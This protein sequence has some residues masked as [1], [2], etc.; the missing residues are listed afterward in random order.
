MGEMLREGSSRVQGGCNLKPGFYHKISFLILFCL[1]VF[2]PILRGQVD[3]TYHSQYRYLKGKDASSITSSWSGPGYDASS[4]QEGP[5]PFRYGDGAGGTELTDMAGSYTTLYLKTGFT[6]T[7]AAQIKKITVTADYDD[8]FIIWI[9]GIRALS[10]NAPATPAAGS[11][12]PGNHE[13]GTGEITEIDAVP[14]NLADGLNTIAVQCFNVSLSSTDFYFDM[15]LRAEPDIPGIADSSTVSFSIPSG[16]YSTPFDVLLSAGSEGDVIVYTLDGSNPVSSLTSFRVTSPAT[17]RVDPASTSGRPATPAFIIRASVSRDGFKPSFPLARTYIFSEKVKTQSWPGGAWPKNDVNGQVIDLATDPRVSANPVYAPLFDSSL[18]YIPSV[19]V[20]TDIKNLFDPASGIYVNADGHGL[21]WEK[22]CSVELFYPDG[23]EGFNINAGLRIRGGYSRH[24]SYPKHAFRLF[25]R[26]EYGAAKLKYP[27]FGNEGVD[28]FDKVDLRCEQ[29][30][31]WNNGGSQNSFVREIFSRDTQRE[32]GQPYTRSRYCHLYLNGMYWGLYMTQERPEARFA[33]SYF[34]DDSED[35]DV[36]KVNMENWQYNIEATDGNLDSW[37]RLLNMCN[38]GFS[39]DAN[40]NALEGKD[41]GGNPYRG[42]EIMVDIDNL[43][44]YMLIIFFT[45]NIDAPT[46]VFMGNKKANNFYAIDNRNDRSQGFVFFAHDSEHSLF[47]DAISPGLGLYENR[48]NIGSRTDNLRM[49]V[50]GISSFHP[51]WLHYK[52]TSNPEYV[53]RFQSR[54]Y[55]HFRKGGVFTT[56][57]ALARINR[58]VRQVDLAVI[59]ESARWGDAK[60]GTASPYTRNEHWMNEINKI[61]D[62]YLRYRPEIV[63]SQLR[64]E[65]LWP[66]LEAPVF[67]VDGY[68]VDTTFLKLENPSFVTIENPG[69]AGVLV[70]TSDGIDPRQYG[71]KLY[72]GA[73]TVNTSEKLEIST[74]AVIKAR[75]LDKGSW[76]ALST[77][78]LAAEEQDYTGLKLTEIQY[79]PPDYVTGSDTIAGQDLEYLEFK[80]TGSNALNL[81]GLKL[82][83]AVRMSFPDNYILPSGKFFVAAS[84]PSKFYNYYGLVAS[85]N[86]SGNLSNAGEEIIL[87][88]KNDRLLMSMSYSDQIPWPGEADGDGYSLASAVNNPS[89]NPSEPVYWTRSL[90]KGG[91][92]FADNNIG[93]DPE[94]TENEL[95]AIAYPNPTTGLINIRINSYDPESLFTII[96]SDMTGRI[97]GRIDTGR[98]S[99]VDLRRFN[100]KPGAYILT[101]RSGRLT[102]KLRLI[103]VR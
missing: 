72:A 20:I 63:I 31:G 49:E 44:D 26:E 83:S 59:A 76:S 2:T 66:K 28:E 93:V 25:F 86:F 87:A 43:I 23:R 19:S 90:S 37:Q 8:G 81:T 88:A 9:N 21:N 33:E 29:N 94:L 71:G 62:V 60:R 51:Q 13:S 12:A 80:N 15:A 92:P 47:S 34:G 17:I 45:G 30:Y 82:D 73:V 79:H 84:K 16:F 53:A 6:A 36:V 91:N 7:N 85:G 98:E 46:A 97:A 67:K 11:V 50:S 54:A 40:Y 70:Y 38:D 68:T 35:Y 52:L 3:F 103:I 58:R 100:A 78:C 32:M 99:V 55:N 57:K 95:D 39:T 14:L 27:L 74:S 75:V 101:I 56:D 18:R 10:V 1:T 42:G 24:D 96:L 5:A 65:G 64:D 69:K 102:R 22:E 4:W 48:V 61:R 89:G 77:L 41:P